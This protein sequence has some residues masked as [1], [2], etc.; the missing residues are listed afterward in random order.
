VARNL[1]TLLAGFLLML[2]EAVYIGLFAVDNWLP[3]I[4]VGVMIYLA[5][6]KGLFEAC[7]AVLLLT[8]VA[9]LLS[10][11]PPGIVA[12]SLTLT[13]FAVYVSNRTVA[14]RGWPVRIALSVVAAIFAQTAAAVLLVAFSRE[15]TVLPALAFSG[16]PSA[17]LAPVGLVISWAALAWIDKTFAARQRGLLT[18]S[19]G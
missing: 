8:W 16:L 19:G 13:F 10:A 7:V 2:L 4:G 1:I 6:R 5:L 11:A 9:D 3:H 14:Y 17:L 15:L 12:M 18:T